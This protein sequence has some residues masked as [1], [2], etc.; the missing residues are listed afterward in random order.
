MMSDLDRIMIVDDEPAIRLFLSDEL[1]QAGYQVST[2]ASGEEALARLQTTSVDLVLLD[3]MMGGMNG[4]DVIEAIEKQPNFPVVIMLT[5]HASVDSAIN[6]FRHGGHDYLI[7]PCQTEELLASVKRGL[8]KSREALEQKKKIELIE[9]TAHQL[10][11]EKSLIADMSPFHQRYLKGRGLVLDNEQ[12]IVTK[13]SKPL[14]LTPTEFRILKCLMERPDRPVSY[15]QLAASLHGQGGSKWENRKAL[16]TH[17]WR[18]MLKV[19][20]ALDGDNYI[21]NVRGRGYQF[22][23]KPPGK[24]TFSPN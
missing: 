13:N 18:L 17:I 8:E 20:R 23:S 22:L 6:V 4:L 3:L 7:K 16:T 11:G 15:N 1:T 24:E 21:V 12:E 5:A 9:Q 10:R 14:E 19:G 2:A